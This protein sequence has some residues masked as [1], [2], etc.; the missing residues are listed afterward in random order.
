M[1]TSQTIIICF[2]C[3]CKAGVNLCIVNQFVMFVF[4]I[5]MYF[6]P[7]CYCLSC[8]SKCSTV[9]LCMSLLYVLFSTLP[10]LYM[11]KRISRIM[12]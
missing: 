3:F 9:C 5:Y 7:F 2:V 6:V 1:A 11:S 10:W 4:F 8:F 12:F